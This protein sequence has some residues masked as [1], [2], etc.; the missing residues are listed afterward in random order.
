MI[1]DKRSIGILGGMGP[2]ATALFY[3]AVIEEC[4]QQY[5]AKNDED[6]PE[7]FICSLPIP[8]PIINFKE[9]NKILPMLID[10][11]DKLKMVGANFVSIPC[12]TVHFFYD[13]LVSDQDI[14]IIN[15]IE[16]TAKKLNLKKIKSIG[17]LA[18]TSTIS[19]RLYQKV[20]EKFGIEI[21]IPE[22]QDMIT[23]I[24]L[25]ILAGNKN[26]G[27]KNTLI[28]IGRS[29]ID[30]GAEGI[31]LGCTE[32]PILINK[33]DVEFELFDTLKILAEVSVEKALGIN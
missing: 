32:L 20:F 33:K 26:Q 28:K 6:Y 19:N 13:D 11:I 18:T 7:I 4:Q 27:D 21:F 30:Y 24:I 10:G 25:N 9:S 3:Q 23:Q 12:N 22:N 16:E 14:P 2:E 31:V 5:G 8:S 1:K 17:L 29:L 15:M